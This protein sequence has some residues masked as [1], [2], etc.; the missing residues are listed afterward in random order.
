M[1]K[2]FFYLLLLAFLVMPMSTFAHTYEKDVIYNQMLTFWRNRNYSAIDSYVSELEQNCSNFIPAIMAIVFH[3][4]AFTG[5]HQG[6]LAL[7]KKVRAHLENKNIKNIDDLLSILNSEISSIEEYLQEGL[8]DVP[9][10]SDIRTYFDGGFV[11]EETPIL[12][13]IPL[14]PEEDIE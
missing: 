7:L 13:L 5:D 1:K 10:P 6:S 4:A 2:T 14:F 3:K 11:I 8:V 12:S 9:N